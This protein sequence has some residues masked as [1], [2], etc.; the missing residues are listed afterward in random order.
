MIE[1]KNELNI[2][3]DSFQCIRDYLKGGWE[4]RKY[5]IGLLATVIEQNGIFTWDRFGRFGQADK[6]AKMSILNLLARIYEYENDC[7]D[8]HDHDQH[9]LDEASYMPDDPFS[10]FGWLKDDLPNFEAIAEQEKEA[11]RPKP[12]LPKP[13]DKSAATKKIQTYLIIIGALCD[14]AGIDYKK[15]GVAKEIEKIMEYK[16][17]RRSEDTILKILKEVPEVYD[18]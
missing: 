14:K 9:P 1:D 18:E 15:P 2:E 7:Y 4:H 12:P 13:Q 5:S 16:R 8:P 3:S 6:C 17:S 10:L 11:T